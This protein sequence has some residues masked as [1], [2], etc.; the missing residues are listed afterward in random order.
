[1]K[2][3]RIKPIK[4]YP[5][6]KVYMIFSFSGF[7]TFSPV[8]FIFILMTLQFSLSAGIQYHVFGLLQSCCKS[9]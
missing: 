6:L 7:L 5:L 1:M 4:S 9:F 3:R 2:S 8:Y